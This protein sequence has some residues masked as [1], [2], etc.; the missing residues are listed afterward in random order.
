MVFWCMAKYSIVTFALGNE[1]PR[2]LNSDDF[3]RI[4]FWYFVLYELVNVSF[5]WLV[6]LLGCLVFFVFIREDTFLI[7]TLF[8]N[9]ENIS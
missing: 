1:T 6:R 5:C 9:W 8:D 2:Y 7:C 4:S 3:F